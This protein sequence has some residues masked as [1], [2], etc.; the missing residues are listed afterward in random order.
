MKD[1]R[2]HIRLPEQLKKEIQ[3]YARRHHTTMNALIEQYFRRLLD[4][5]KKELLL[6]DIEVGEQI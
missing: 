6:L 4:E 3:G 2:A 1:G 5:E